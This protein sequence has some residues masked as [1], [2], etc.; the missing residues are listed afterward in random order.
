M[1]ILDDF[2]KTI[3][4]QR[5]RYTSEQRKAETERIARENEAK[6][7]AALE[8]EWAAREE[9]AKLKARRQD[10]AA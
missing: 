7:K 6:A 9:E 8:Q 5:S 3:K 4:G 1:G 10:R 2:I